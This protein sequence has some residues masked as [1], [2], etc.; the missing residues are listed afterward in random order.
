MK[1]AKKALLLTVCALV[2]VAATVFGTMAYL[3][4]AD[5][6]DNTF[7][8]GKID[9]KLDEAKTNEDGEP[10][11][12]NDVITSWDDADRVQGNE[13]HLVPGCVYH[14]DPVVWVQPNSEKSI[15]Y[16]TVDNQMAPVVE[17]KFLD[18]QIDKYGWDKLVDVNGDPVLKDG[19]QVYFQ[20]APETDAETTLD[21][22]VF[23]S[24]RVDMD[25]D[26]KALEAV[27]DNH[28]IINAYAVQQAGWS[29]DLG[30]VTRPLTGK[31]LAVTAWEGSFG[32]PT[33]E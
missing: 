13:Y 1:T 28:I 30:P 10:M 31:A 8:V 3:S 4:D 14:K 24:I 20:F 18:D 9:I 23:S 26:Q 25:A 22:I 29:E 7:T 21:Y 17:Q 16:V 27:Q 32:A 6:V 11:K 19:K 15:L 5:K 2:L 33:V 12:G